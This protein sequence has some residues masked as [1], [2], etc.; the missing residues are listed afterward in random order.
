MIMSDKVDLDE[1]GICGCKSFHLYKNYVVC[2]NC[3]NHSHKQWINIK[4]E[5]KE[6][7]F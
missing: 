2:D 4:K 1:C 6:R 5:W 3:S 7:V